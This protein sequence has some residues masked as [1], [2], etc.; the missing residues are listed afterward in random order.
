MGV[1]YW[2]KMT[3]KQ[4]LLFHFLNLGTQRHRRNNFQH[5]SIYSFFVLSRTSLRCSNLNSH[6]LHHDLLLLPLLLARLN[7]F[8]T[9][10]LKPL[11]T[12][13]SPPSPPNKCYCIVGYKIYI[14]IHYPTLVN[15]I[16]RLLLSSVKRVALARC[17]NWTVLLPFRTLRF[18]APSSGTAVLNQCANLD[19]E[20]STCF[21]LAKLK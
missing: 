3:D 19:I 8:C 10:H 18:T 21:R 5:W 2:V 1:C 20:L 13:R 16:L 9:W 4:T 14:I 12:Y 11:T 6:H 7:F 17:L 15:N